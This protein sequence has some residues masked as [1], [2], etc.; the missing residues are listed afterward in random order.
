MAEIHNCQKQSPCENF[1][2]YS[3][4]CWVLCCIPWDVRNPV[5]LFHKLPHEVRHAKDYD[6]TLVGREQEVCK[7]DQEGI[8]D[9]RH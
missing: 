4:G 5:E 1:H 3:N 9:S 7:Q 6:E 2:I 8:P